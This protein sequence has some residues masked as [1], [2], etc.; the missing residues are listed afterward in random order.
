[1]LSIGRAIPEDHSDPLTLLAAFG[2]IV[3]LVSLWFT[4]FGRTE[5]VVV[6]LVVLAA[7]A[8]LVIAHPDDARAGLGGVLLLVGRAPSSGRRRPTSG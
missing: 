1:V 2:G 8:E 7:G 4:Y 5:E 3:A 6:G